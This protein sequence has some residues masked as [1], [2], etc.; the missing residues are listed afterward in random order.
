MRLAYRNSSVRTAR[1][2]TAQISRAH[3]AFLVEALVAMAVFSIAIAG[4]FGLVANALRASSNALAR[5]HAAGLAAS[6]LA[7]MSA[8]DLATLTVRYD[9][10]SAGA[11]FRELANDAGRLPGV[12]ATVNLPSVT[13]VSG[14][15]IQ[16]RRAAIAIYWQLPSETTRHRMSMTT[17]VAR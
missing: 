12:T 7:R 8:E 4:T 2:C 3:G 5:A 17:V 10:S 9:A 13:V 16:S 1:G 15:S 11:A 14:P 6:T